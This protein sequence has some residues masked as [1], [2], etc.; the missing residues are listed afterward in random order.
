MSRK[1]VRV[2]IPTGSPDDLLT[3]GLKIKAKHDKDGAASPLDAKKMTVLRAALAIAGPKHQEAKDADGVAQ[4]AR[5]VRDSALG[6]AGGQNVNTKDTALNLITYERDQLLLSND[7]NEEALTGY[8]FN[9]VVGAAKARAA[10]P[11][12]K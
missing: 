1:T 10:K 7:G 12:A 6:V 11:A 9:V 3:L 8:G 5:Q 2:D 4:A